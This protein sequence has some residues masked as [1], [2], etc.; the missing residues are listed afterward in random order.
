MDDEQQDV[1]DQ[2]TG[3]GMCERCRGIPWDDIYLEQENLNFIH[4]MTESADELSI[5]T[6]RTCQIFGKV[7]SHDR[8]PQYPEPKRRLRVSGVYSRAIESLQRLSE[9]S[10]GDK[11]VLHSNES[12]ATEQESLDEIRHWD[13]YKDAEAVSLMIEDL[14]YGLWSH[15]S[16]TMMLT[17]QDPLGEESTFR[18]ILPIKLNI[19]RLVSWIDTCEIS[20]DRICSPAQVNSLKNL[21]VIDCELKKVVAAPKGSKYAALSYVWGT[22]GQPT[23]I[24]TSAL[25]NVPLVIE[26]AISLVQ[27]MGYRYLWVDRYVSPTL[28]KL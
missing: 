6:C 19:S 11:N 22:S 18:D 24:Q 12:M 28:T 26:D 23:L 14:R 4:N 10:S 2:S 16:K 1:T 7:I 13:T 27:Q 8:N 3:D 15:G 17:R 21:Q 5:S 9:I 25:E 20:H